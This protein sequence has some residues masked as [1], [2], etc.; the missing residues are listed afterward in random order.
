MKF[1]KVSAFILA[2]I[3][4]VSLAACS[5]ESDQEAINGAALPHYNGVENA[6]EYD[7]DVFYRNDLTALYL[8]HCITAP[9]AR[10]PTV[11][12]ASTA[13]IFHENLTHRSYGTCPRA[14]APM[15]TA[16]VGVMRFTS[17]EA[18]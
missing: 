11:I 7:S 2:T 18:A 4:A 16:A 3:S 14:S 8:F 13:I 10:N 5:G 12:P 6:E 15:T 1:K 17:P 9:I